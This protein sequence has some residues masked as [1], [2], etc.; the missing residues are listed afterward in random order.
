MLTL[1]TVS[2]F[3]LVILYSMAAAS[4]MIALPTKVIFFHLSGFRTS[5]PE[6]ACIY[7]SQVDNNSI[8]ASAPWFSSVMRKYSQLCSSTQA[9]SIPVLNR[10]SYFKGFRLTPELREIL[11]KKGDLSFA[12]IDVW[13]EFVIGCG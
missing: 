4:P 11:F 12:D 3:R 6:L 2:A 13:R 1:Y 9:P 7:L 5:R 8:L 10:F